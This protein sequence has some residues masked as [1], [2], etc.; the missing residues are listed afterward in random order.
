MRI[1]CTPKHAELH[2]E[3]DFDLERICVR[4][5]GRDLGAMLGI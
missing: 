4:V 1:G 3:P 5:L 2:H